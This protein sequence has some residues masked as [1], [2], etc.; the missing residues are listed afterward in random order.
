MGTN[1]RTD[2]KLNS[3]SRI[4]IQLES[5]DHLDNFYNCDYSNIIVRSQ[6]CFGLVYPDGVSPTDICDLPFVICHQVETFPVQSRGPILNLHFSYP[7]IPGDNPFLPEFNIYAISFK[8]TSEKM[9]MF[10]TC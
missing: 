6:W 5:K 4:Y 3:R 9:K 1:E 2:G 8:S 10:L 7:T